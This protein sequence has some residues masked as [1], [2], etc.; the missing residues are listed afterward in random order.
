MT[1]SRSSRRTWH[2][3]ANAVVL[4]YLAAA[5]AWFVVRQ[6]TH[7]G[8]L[9]I[10]L[11][12]LG[13]V[14]NAIMTWSAHF[15]SA[16][17]QLPPPS[18]RRSGAQ[19]VV[20]NIAIVSILSGVEAGRHAVVIAGVAVL[21]GVLAAHGMAL[22]RAV[23]AAHARRFAPTVR[24]YYVATAALI[25]GAAAG[26]ALAVG[27]SSRWQPRLFAAHVQLNLLG[28]VTLTVLG[29]QFSLWPTALRTRMVQGL[30]AAAR[31]CLPACTVGLTLL[32]AGVIAAARPLS[33]AGALLYLAG[34]VLFLDPFVRTARRRAPHSPATWMLGAAT[35][36]LT[37]ALALDAAAL[38]STADPQRLADRVESVVPA[39]LTGFVVQVLLGALTYLLPV[40]LGQGPASGRR[41]TA[42]LDRWGWPRIA[43]LNAGVVLVAL[44]SDTAHAVGWAL[45]GVAVA[46][47]VGLATAASARAAV[48]AG[49]G[50]SR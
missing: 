41:I 7:P 9:V 23:H 15:A 30:E 5:A 24:F 47:F 40:V 46:G 16:L 4:S 10:H 27:V 50:G 12:L 29:T 45:A 31:R 22:A 20:L 42:L 17:L 2:A 25:L 48:C 34:V 32:V 49:R 33:V 18:R 35:G 11:L 13:A 28:W 26:A 8:W 6:S 38:L 21:V 14:T 1:I 43:A 44:P 19:L 3:T 36:W 37:I 39:F